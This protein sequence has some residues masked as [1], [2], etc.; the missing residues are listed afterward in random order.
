MTAQEFEG[1]EQ[2]QDGQEQGGSQQ[3]LVFLMNMRK[4]V[5]KNSSKFANQEEYVNWITKQYDR[6]QEF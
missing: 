1:Q 3:S 6:Q 5:D 2:G 4:R